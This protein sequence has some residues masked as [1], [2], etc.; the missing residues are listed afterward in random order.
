MAFSI[1][2]VGASTPTLNMPTSIG[3]DGDNVQMSGLFRS[4]SAAQAIVV[5]DQ[6]RGLAGNVDEPVVPVFFDSTYATLNGLYRI[7]SVSVDMQPGDGAQW[8]VR[9]QVS[10]FRVT[11]YQSPIIESRIVVGLLTNAHGVVN[12]TARCEFGAVSPATEAPP[13]PPPYLDVVTF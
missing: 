12:T 9:W 6:L 5:R 13:T 10:A 1:G 8:I 2:R 4:S 7:D 11:T 3:F